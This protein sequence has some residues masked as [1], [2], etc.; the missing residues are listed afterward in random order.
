MNTNMGVDKGG[1][2]ART[3]WYAVIVALGAMLFMVVY[4]AR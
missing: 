3:V 2:L 1:I 4:L